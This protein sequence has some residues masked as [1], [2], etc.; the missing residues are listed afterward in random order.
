MYI[1]SV[2]REGGRG[3]ERGEEGGEERKREGKERKG[4]Y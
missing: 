3:K 4:H 2:Q 1:F